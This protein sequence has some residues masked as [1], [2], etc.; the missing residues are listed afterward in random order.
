MKTGQIPMEVNTMPGLIVYKSEDK[1]VEIFC[2][3]HQKRDCWSYE[4]WKEKNPNRKTGNTSRIP[5]S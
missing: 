5:V 3:N 2:K 1:R 4:G